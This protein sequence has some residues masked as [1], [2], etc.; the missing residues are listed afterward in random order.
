VSKKGVKALGL[1]S[2][3]WRGGGRKMKA[4]MSFVRFE[5]GSHEGENEGRMSGHDENWKSNHHGL[6]ECAPS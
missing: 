4:R 1:S 5:R 2:P 3:K 6:Q